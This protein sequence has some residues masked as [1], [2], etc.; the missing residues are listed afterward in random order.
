MSYKS[1]KCFYYER[2]KFCK[3]GAACQ[4]AHSDQDIKTPNELSMLNQIATAIN[5]GLSADN[6]YGENDYS[7][8]MN[9]DPQMYQ[10]YVNQVYNQQNSNYAMPEYDYY[11]TPDT[12]YGQTESNPAQDNS[13]SVSNIIRETANSN[14]NKNEKDKKNRITFDI[15]K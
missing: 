14:E 12:N 6:Q 4:Y 9:L 15:K 8:Y 2:D 3:H 1:L 10:Q 13:M 11:Y 7:Q 5:Y